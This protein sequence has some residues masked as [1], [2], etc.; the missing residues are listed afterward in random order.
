[1]SD[2]AVLWTVAIS[3]A[4]YGVAAAV[5]TWCLWRVHG[6]FV[7]LVLLVLG[8]YAALARQVLVALPVLSGVSVEAT[9]PWRTVILPNVISWLWAGSAF[10]WLWFLKRRLV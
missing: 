6:A 5:Y 1:M 9:E 4:L 2:S 7:P 10:A 3:T 8:S